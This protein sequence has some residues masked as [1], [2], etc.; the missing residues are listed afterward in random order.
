MMTFSKD[1]E[2]ARYVLARIASYLASL[3]DVG[4]SNHIA[5]SILSPVGG[6]KL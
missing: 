3:L 5:Y 6:F 2:I 1:T 4:R